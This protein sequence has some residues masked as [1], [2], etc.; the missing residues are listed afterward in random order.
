M[1]AFI[2]RLYQ[3]NTKLS[4]NYDNCLTYTSLIV[5]NLMGAITFCELKKDTYAPDVN[6]ECIGE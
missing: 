6:D 5:L 4:L 2:L 3:I 1:V